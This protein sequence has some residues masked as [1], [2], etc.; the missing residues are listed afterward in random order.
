MYA[1]TTGTRAALPLLRVGVVVARADARLAD[2]MVLGRGDAAAVVVAGVALLTVDE[3]GVDG[4]PLV[5][6]CRGPHAPSSTEPPT[7]ASAK[8]APLR[9]R[10]SRARDVTR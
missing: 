8:P 6:A 10:R 4:I 3:D 7:R 9:L 1:A 2:C 5:A